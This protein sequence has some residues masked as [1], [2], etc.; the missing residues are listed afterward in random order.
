MTGK[1]KE[2]NVPFARTPGSVD[3]RVS[4]PSVSEFQRSYNVVY[5]GGSDIEEVEKA[6]F[7]LRQEINNDIQSIPKTWRPESYRSPPCS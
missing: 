7:A 2:T 3:P 6:E 1:K 5:H 4:R